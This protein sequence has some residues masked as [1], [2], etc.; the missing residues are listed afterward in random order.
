MKIM[1]TLLIACAATI[2]IPT[3]APAKT[4]SDTNFT[5]AVIPDTQNYTDYRHQKNEGFAFDAAELL[6]QQMQYVADNSISQGGDIVFATQLGDNWQHQTLPIDPNHEKRGFK[7]VDNPV[8]EKGYALTPKVLTVEAP[9]AR[10][11]W[12][13]VAGKLPFS[14]VPGNHDYD[15]MWTDARHPPKPVVKSLADVG[16]LHVGG[17]DNW[18]SVFSSQ[19]PFFKGKPWYVA[20]HDG[21]ADSAQIFTAAGYKFLHIGLQFEAP[22]ASLEWAESIIKRYPGLPTIISTHNYLDLSGAREAHPLLNGH[23]IDPLDNDPPLVWSKFI[24]KHDQIFMVLAGHV[25]GQSRRID[26]NG[27]GHPVW[28][29]MSDYQGRQQTA[30][31]AGTKAVAEGIG[32]GWMRLM[33]FDFSGSTPKV[34]VRTY[35]THYKKFSTEEPNY[36]SWYKAQEH[37]QHSDAEY[38]DDDDFTL[39]LTGFRQRFGAPKNH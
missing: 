12:N 24:S 10:E 31:D 20:S 39:E 8:L 34:K 37:P 36:N 30:K 4:L 21:G 14:V 29:I 27:S 17:L 6:L 32:D 26:D 15:A 16:S 35:S 28:Q 23:F 7:R 11:A 22:N 1:K 5:I 2:S 25:A 3:V 19:S 13:L 33:Q 9:A 38:L 18:R